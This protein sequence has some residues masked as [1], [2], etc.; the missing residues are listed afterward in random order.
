[1]ALA[2]FRMVIHELLKKDPAIVP[3]EAPIIVLYSKSAICM[4]KNGRDTKHTRNIAMRMHFVW[5]REKCKMHKIDL[6]VGG[7]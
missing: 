3:E 4:A 6:C 5:N 2:Y 7:L 1:M